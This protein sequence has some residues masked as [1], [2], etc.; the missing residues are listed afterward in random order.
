M[1]RSEIR[2]LSVGEHA[3]LNRLVEILQVYILAPETCFVVQLVSKLSQANMKVSI[4]HD[5]G[6]LDVEV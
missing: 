5:D 1:P 6:S 3:I 2:G 4:N